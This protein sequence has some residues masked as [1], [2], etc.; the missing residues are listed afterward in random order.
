MF[1]YLLSI[2]VAFLFFGTLNN[3]LLN[4]NLDWYYNKNEYEIAWVSVGLASLVWF[5]ALPLLFLFLIMFLLKLLT[6]KISAYIINHIKDR[7]LNKSLS[8]QN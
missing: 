2:G 4:L 3:I 8:K 7:K 6:D 5:F 1:S